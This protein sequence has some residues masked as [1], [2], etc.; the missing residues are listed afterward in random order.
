MKLLRGGRIQASGDAPIERRDI[1]IDERGY[2]AALLAPGEPIAGGMPPGSG[3]PLD[4]E[5]PSNAGSPAAS[6]RRRGAELITIDLAD[7]LVVPG[8]VDAHQHLDK[9]H[10]LRDVPNPQGTLDGAIAAFADYATK[11]TRANVIAHAERT[12]RA[13]S[14][15]GTVA[16]RSH[17]NIDPECGLRNAEALIELRSGWQDRM[18]LQVVAFI[19]SG[20]INNPKGNV[21]LDEALAMGADVV[22]GT[23]TR[24][25]DVDDFLDMLFDASQRYGRPIDVH[26]DEHLDVNAV[27][28]D[29]LADRT[30]ALGMQGKVV[31]SHSSV[32][33]ALPPDEANR[34]IDRL[35]HAGIGVITL[36]A[37]N[38]FLQGRHA[39]RL[40]P[41]GL[42]RVNEL[43]RAGVTV[44]C[45]SDNIRDPFVPTGSG[46]MLE[47]ARWTV[48]A[49]HLGSK[50][51]G[52]AF[53]MTGGNPARLLRIDAE[54]GLKVGARADLLITKAEDAADLVAGGALERY[55]LVGGNPVAGQL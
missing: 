13:C 8:L 54:H 30:V 52:R 45:A 34:I 36:P 33:S 40:P 19:T 15:R 2:I 39:D 1:L 10:T 44:A 22:G 43:A 37:A 6:A 41:R 17:A 26:M 46:D 47:I 3:I 42:T 31:A 16:I 55:V 25:H 9:S 35:A 48:L 27:H 7:R 23:P 38:L 28:F 32:L 20:A 18:R 5:V 51:L 24:A 21:W 4:R 53:D 29:A 50:D 49:A 12:L 11:L 14:A